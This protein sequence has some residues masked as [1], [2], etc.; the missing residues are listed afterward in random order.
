[1]QNVFEDALVLCRFAKV[2]LWSS[3]VIAAE[4][5]A[6]RVE[7]GPVTGQLN[8][9]PAYLLDLHDSHLR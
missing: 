1:M 5:T 4:L 8:F 6:V 2:S 9:R 3:L 7:S